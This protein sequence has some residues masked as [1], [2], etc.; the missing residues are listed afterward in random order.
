MAGQG[1]EW[2]AVELVSFSLVNFFCVTSQFP[3]HKS[4]VS[5]TGDKDRGFFIFLDGVAAGDTGDPVVVAFD[6]QEALGGRV[7]TGFVGSNPL[8]TVP[9]C[10]LIV[11]EVADRIP[12]PAPRGRVF[13]IFG[14]VAGTRTAM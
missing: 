1:L 6:Q 3:D 8:R 11:V 7:D 5:G 13:G 4:S 9:G 12:V 10:E 2:D 14:V